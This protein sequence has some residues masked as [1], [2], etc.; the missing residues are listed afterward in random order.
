MCNGEQILLK[1][2]GNFN[3]HTMKNDDL[4][5]VINE[6]EHDVFRKKK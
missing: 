3:V 6:Q 5:F 1:G 4:I 2:L